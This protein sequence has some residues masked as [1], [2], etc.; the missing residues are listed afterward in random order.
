MPG[1]A[2]AVLQRLPPCETLRAPRAL[3]LA[4]DGIAEAPLRR[5]FPHVGRFERLTTRAARGV[6][7]VDPGPPPSLPSAMLA[8]LRRAPAPVVLVDPLEETSGR[9]L[10]QLRRA[11]CG[12]LVR[13]TARGWERFSLGGAGWRKAWARLA[14]RRRARASDEDGALARFLAARPALR[15][16]PLPREGPLDVL[17]V[18]GP[19][20]AGGAERQLALLAVALHEAGHRVRVRT[21]SP[22]VGE[23]AHQLPVLAAAGVDARAAGERVADAAVARLLALPWDAGVLAAL[24]GAIRV[25]ALDLAGELL[26]DPPPDV[27]HGFLD[28]PNIV[29]AVAALLVG[30]PRAVLSTRNLAPPRFPAF[31]RPWM[32]TWYRRVL[33]SPGVRLVANSAAGAA[34]YARWLGTRVPIP[35][36]PNAVAPP[37]LPDGGAVAALRAEL[38]LPPGA[39]VVLG[40]FRLAPEKRPDRWVRVVARARTR[41]PTLRAVVAGEGPLAADLDRAIARA[42]LTDAVRRVGRRADVATFLALADV[43]LLTSDAEGQPNVLLEAQA[44]GC[45]VVATRV[46]GVPECVVDGVTGSLRAPDDVAGLADAVVALVEDEAGRAAR[47]E[48]GRAHVAARF[49]PGRAREA[50]LALY[51]G[52]E[53]GAR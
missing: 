42:G 33:G 16:R 5:A 23:G 21:T 3:V 27:L 11:G 8:G 41:C 43:V 36:V 14:G 13:R 32:E 24:P 15:P 20:T 1:Y 6:Q 49:S 52:L 40:V 39:P 9:L 37:P 2:E 19:L 7:A 48:A 22:L 44:A 17:L 34:D 29:V 25:P 53:G 10:V 46:G 4:M 31:H 12:P 50:T 26:V 28:A 45:A 51:R 47:A 30:H 35:V 38:G 18:T